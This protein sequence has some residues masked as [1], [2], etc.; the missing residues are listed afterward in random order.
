MAQWLIKEFSKL[1]KVTVR[2]L[3]H[4]DSIGLLGPSIRQSNGYR[5]YS[6]ADLLKLQQILALKFFGFELS[7]IQGL[8]KENSNTFRHFQNQKQVLTQKI[9]QLSRAKRALESVISDLEQNEFINWKKTLKLIEEY[10]MV[11]ETKAVWGSDANKQSEH[12]ES[13]VEKGLVTCEQLMEAQSRMQTWSANEVKA[14][15]EEQIELFKALASAMSRSLTPESQEV[16]KLTSKHYEI[17][18]RFWNFTKESYLALANYY[19]TEVEMKKVFN[20]YH[21]NLGEFLA[22]A[23]RT[24]AKDKLK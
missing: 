1:T 7:E 9:S 21:A 14:I 15:Q 8:Q 3:H 19:Q 13:L 6:E 17:M 24:Y 2:T 12:Q 23:M 18:D 5:L 4:Y 11:Q 20:P 10:Q 16:Q 22:S